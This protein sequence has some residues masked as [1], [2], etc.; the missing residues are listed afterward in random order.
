MKRN[1]MTSLDWFPIIALIVVLATLWIFK[2]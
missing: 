2:L 1:K